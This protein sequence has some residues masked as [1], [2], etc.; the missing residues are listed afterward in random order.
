MNSWYTEKLMNVGKTGT[1]REDK[2][3][4]ARYT[5]VLS[6]YRV[7]TNTKADEVIVLALLYFC[8]CCPYGIFRIKPFTSK[9]LN[10]TKSR[11]PTQ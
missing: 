4:P 1:P 9:S 6:C 5:I 3:S 7:L 11:Q 8:C 10:P 2:E